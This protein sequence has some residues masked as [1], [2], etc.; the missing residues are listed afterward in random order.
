MRNNHIKILLDLKGVFIKKVL[1]DTD[2]ISIYLETKPKPHICPHCGSTTK[3]IH[4]YRTQVIKDLP[5]QNK[6]TKLILRKRRYACSCGKRFTEK[7]NF[8]PVYHR[9]TTRVIS[10]IIYELKENYSMKSVAKRLGLSSNTIARVFDHINYSCTSLPEV[11][12]IDEFKG[13]SDKTKYHCSIVDPVT[14]Q[15]LDVIKN[16]QL[17]HLYTHFKPY[18]RDH[19][20][21]FVCDMYKPYIELAKNYFKNATIIIDKYHFQRQSTWAF[22]NVRKRIQKTMSKKY[23]RYYKRSRRLLLKP[24]SKL[25]PYAKEEVDIMLI[26]SEDLRQAYLLKELFR[27]FMHSKSS[28]EA[29]TLL[30]QWIDNAY[31]SGLPEFKKC[32]NTYSTWSKEILAA[33]DV[34][35]TNGCIEGYNNKIKVIKRNAFG[36]K[37]FTRFRNRIIHCS[38]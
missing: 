13:N 19:V 30:K 3:K 1:N 32:A 29:R 22:E 24:S 31:S 16:R 18:K 33:F 12:S 20:K 15:L 34:P 9:M 37:N 23:R 14:H 21:Y 35:Y 8:L 10:T 25:S 4:D 7:Y 2:F 27:K 28:K 26:Y 17:H 36:Y 38:S 6:Q 11:L 5:M